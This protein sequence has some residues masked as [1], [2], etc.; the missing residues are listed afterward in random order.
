MARTIIDIHVIQTVPPSNLNRDDTGSPK[1]AIYGGQRRARVSSQAWKR[2]TRHAF[3]GL[4]DDSEL[5]VRTKRVVELLAQEITAQDAG[6]AESAVELAT[7]VLTAAGI[8][9]KAPRKADALHEAEFL[10][11]LSRRQVQ[12]LAELAITAAHDAGEGKVAVDKKEA[13]ARADREHSVDVSLFGRMVANATDLNVDA[14]AQVAHA[15]SV[16]AV[17]NEYDYFTAV[18]DHKNA[19]DMEDAGA[20]MIGTVEFNSST[21]YRYATV[22]VNRL[23]DNLG[24]AQATRRAV[25]A[26]VRAFVSSMPTGKQNTF[27]NRTLPDAVLVVARETQSINL[28]GAFE[29]AIYAQTGRI[30]EAIQRLTDH[31]RDLHQA[32]D[33]QPVAAWAFGVGD[34][35][36]APLSELAQRS[37]FDTTV[38][39]VGALVAGRLAAQP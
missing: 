17:D 30:A 36:V 34:K 6:L 22:D 25:E 37:T 9:V 2:A 5:G 19:D 10:L 20:G 23:Q 32:Y 33:E 7:E 1:T 21:L 11:F 38:T 4:L 14:A 39:E 13:R 29:E 12:N 31:A 24:D 8:T 27:A 15:L 28:V 16:H 18:D 26:F 35:K 3:A